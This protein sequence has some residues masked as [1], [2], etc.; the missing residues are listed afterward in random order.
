MESTAGGQ[1]FLL[2]GTFDCW[3]VR[4]T[5]AKLFNISVHRARL[6]VAQT[7]AAGQTKQKNSGQRT[8]KRWWNLSNGF[9][10]ACDKM[11]QLSHV[12]LNFIMHG[13]LK[14]KKKK[15]KKNSVQVGLPFP[16]KA[17]GRQSEFN[18]GHLQGCLTWIGE[19]FL[20]HQM[21]C[22]LGVYVGFFWSAKKLYLHCFAYCLLFKD[23]KSLFYWP[24]NLKVSCC[25]AN[26]GVKC[27]L[28]AMAPLPPG[29]R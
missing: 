6:E 24:I 4:R 25:S 12:T 8:F 9:T 27:K 26:W 22:L 28:F 15:K 10:S 3:I 17:D 2:L 29:G 18:P 23:H 14:K 16:L 13:C 7:S 11:L 5:S 19:T 21:P 20:L 1:C